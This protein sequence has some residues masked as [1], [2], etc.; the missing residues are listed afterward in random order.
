MP[1]PPDIIPAATALPCALASAHRAAPAP[2]DG[3]R[4]K[5]VILSGVLDISLVWA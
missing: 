2:P 5:G 1:R 3:A 4:E